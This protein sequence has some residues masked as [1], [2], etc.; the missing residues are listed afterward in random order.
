MRTFILINLFHRPVT[1]NSLWP[2]GLTVACQASLSLT[3]SWNLPELMFIASDFTISPSDT[4]FPFCPWSSPTSGSFLINH[5]FIPDDQNTGA[6]AF[7][8]VLPVTIKGWFPLR[9]TGLISLLSKGLSGGFSSTTVWRHQL[10]GILT[11]YGPAI[12]DRWEDHSLDFWL[13]G[14][15]SA[16]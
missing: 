2:H 6:S 7:T 4:L 5:L 15:F 12:C 16:E 8:S 9:L 3:I 1:S 10:F 13:Y 14:L 11:S